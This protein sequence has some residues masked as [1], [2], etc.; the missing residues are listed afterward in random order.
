MGKIRIGVMGCA[1]IAQRSVIPAILELPEKFELVAIASRTQ[2]KA[3]EFALRFGCESIGSYDALLARNDI[4]AIYMPLPTGLHKEWIN[5]TIKARK[6]LYA[7]KSFAMNFADAK[8]MIKK[9]MDNNLALMEGYM[10]QYHTQHQ[11]VFE[12]INGG[13]IGEIRSFKASFGFPPFTDHNNFRYNNQVGGGAL[14][15]TAGYVICAASFIL[16]RE[17]VAQGASVYYEPLTGTSLY[18][19]AFLASIGGVGAQ[20]SFGFSNYYQCNYEIWGS[21]GKLT[22]EHAFTPKPNESTILLL[23]NADGIQKIKCPPYNQFKGA[24]EEFYNIC[25]G[26]DRIK[27]YKQ[28]LWQSE[29]LSRIEQISKQ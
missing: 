3:D 26:S 11:K 14:K 28:I 1:N 23:E 22:A 6:Y 20:L 25:N 15:D 13:S 9:A 18:G 2:E 8:E 27:H 5:R 12:L 24:M 29:T 21:K 17:L 10:F 19:N 16:Q 4:D 7:E